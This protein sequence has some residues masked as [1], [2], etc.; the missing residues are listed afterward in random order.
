VLSLI[1][2]PCYQWQLETC[3]IRVLDSEYLLP[4]LFPIENNVLSQRR[5]SILMYI[6]I[7]VDSGNDAPDDN[8]L[9]TKLH[10]RRGANIELGVSR[11]SCY[12]KKQLRIWKLTVYL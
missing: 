9:L 1:I 5:I 7:I 6:P 11:T 4:E 2:L 10:L 8:I 12:E 3:A